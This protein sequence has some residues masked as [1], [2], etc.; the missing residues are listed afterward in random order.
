[1]SS[2]TVKKIDVQTIYERRDQKIAE[3]RRG[4]WL[5]LHPDY[6]REYE[7]WTPRLKTRLI[8]SI[9]LGRRMNP[10]WTVFNK[11]ENTEEVIDGMHRLTT[12]IGFFTDEFALVGNCLME[13]P[14]EWGG[15]TFSKMDAEYQ[16]RFR[17]YEFDF[18]KLD[19]SYR[20]QPQKLLD[21]YEILNRS[22][23]PLNEYEF[24]KILFLALYNGL[25]PYVASFT[26][27]ILFQKERSRRG[28][29]KSKMIETIALAD[30][31]LPKRWSGLTAISKKWL[32]S[33]G[34][35]ADTIQSEIT[36]RMPAIRERLDEIVYVMMRYTELH[37]FDAAFG[38]TWRHIESLF[39]ITRTAFHFAGDHARL[40]RH[41]PS[42]VETFREAFFEEKDA[43]QEKINRD[44]RFQVRLVATIDEILQRELG[45]PEPRCFPAKM[46][47]QRLSEQEGK[48]GICHLPILERDRYEGDHILPWSQK[49][50][51]VIENLQVVHRSCHRAK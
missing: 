5:N 41:L 35:R 30:P 39:V 34:G 9:L 23:K 19:S 18:N 14:E 11:T 38:S 27:S 28:A 25:E 7:A 40:N 22:S 3:G 6:Q 13:L 10:I 50:R 24:N 49:G 33:F 26:G 8:E 43:T 29:I 36:K 31:D 4:I 42:L 16:Q 46:I 1:M 2:A 48:C 21:M 17:D 15:K 45:T 32:A 44:G 51:T 12:A 20:E 47:Q 37:L